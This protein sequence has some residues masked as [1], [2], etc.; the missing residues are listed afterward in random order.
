MLAVELT[1][2]RSDSRRSS[3]AGSRLPSHLPI[4]CNVIPAMP[5][6]RQNRLPIP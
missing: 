1:D 5:G 2:S 6:G 3:A 4:G